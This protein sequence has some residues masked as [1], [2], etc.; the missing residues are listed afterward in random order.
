MKPK[1]SRK[2]DPRSDSPFLIEN[3]TQC[4]E[5]RRP[6][7]D[8]KD[9]HGEGTQSRVNFQGT[10]SIAQAGHPVDMCNI[11]FVK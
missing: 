11:T 2:E 7:F 6:E 9:T 3:Y 1:Y 8:G 5:I 4:Y 10:S